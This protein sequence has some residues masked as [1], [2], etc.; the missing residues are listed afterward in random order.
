[1]IFIFEGFILVSKGEWLSKTVISQIAVDKIA[2]TTSSEL[3]LSHENENIF[4]F[5]F[6]LVLKII[7]CF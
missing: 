2:E 6:F 3:K 5:I 1:M 7:L 4:N